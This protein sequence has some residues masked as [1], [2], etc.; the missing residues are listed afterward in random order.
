MG[1]GQYSPRVGGS[2][3][4]PEGDDAGGKKGNAGG[5]DGQKQ[6]HG[7]GG[8]ARVII[9]LVKLLHRADA[10]GSGGIAEPEGAFAERLRIM[11]PMAGC[12]G[13][14]FGNRR[15][16]TGRINRERM[17]SMPPASATFTS[18]RNSV[19]T[20]TR[21]MARS[22]EPEAA[23]LIAF[24]SVSIGGTTVSCEGVHPIC[25]H[26]AQRRR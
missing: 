23:S 24:D 11:A 10:E 2:G 9:E 16:M 4:C 14:T 6:G 1:G 18:P 25:R 22:T 5:V 3:R 17:T 20:P 19:I 8:D 21:P 12:S 7:V 15:I 26:A 13:G